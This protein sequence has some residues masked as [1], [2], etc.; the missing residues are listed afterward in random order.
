[1]SKNL[2][3]RIRKARLKTIES[4]GK[5]FIVRRPTDLEAAEFFAGKIS[6]VDLVKQY[7]TGWEGITEADLVNG[8]SADP[9]PFSP[10]LWAE[11]IVDQP[12]HWQPIVDGV[13]TAYEDHAKDAAE[14]KKNS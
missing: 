8:G 2:I 7:V 9:A 3:E 6:R 13:L 10:E 4:G 11:W 1:M 14:R 5:K 12:D